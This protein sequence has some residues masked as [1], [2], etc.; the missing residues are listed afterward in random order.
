MYGELT[1]IIFVTSGASQHWK[2]DELWGRWALPIER[3][4]KVLNNFL[5]RYVNKSDK[6]I[7]YCSVYPG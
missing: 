3:R 6:L 1:R 2:S 4:C 7:K 5:K